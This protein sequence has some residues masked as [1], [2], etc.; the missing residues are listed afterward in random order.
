L[1]RTREDVIQIA[2][3]VAEQLGEQEV[4][5][6][7]IWGSIV[8]EGRKL[9]DKSDLDLLVIKRRLNLVP[10]P[11]MQIMFGIPTRTV[12]H[13]D[14]KVDIFFVDRS[15]VRRAVE[16][17]HWTV[18]NAIVNGIVI[19][20][21]GILEELRPICSDFRAFSLSTPTEWF[22]Q[23]SNLLQKARSLLDDDE[24]LTSIVLSRH[25]VDAMVHALIYAS[26]GEPASPKSFLSDL[27]ERV[28]N[29]DLY[30]LYLEIQ[31]LRE[32]TKVEAMRTNL[33]ALDFLARIAKRIKQDRG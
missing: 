24:Y 21:H 18:I 10:D 17:K 25:A 7:L 30:E 19:A 1:A 31:G 11:D 27:R 20:D 33:L 13:R 23:A 16:Q 14:A 2:R 6:I 4:E 29:R 12:Y 15:Y 3:E 22:N 9:D 5:A 28:A 32:L 26:L 8:E